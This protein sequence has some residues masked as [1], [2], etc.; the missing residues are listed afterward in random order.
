M[1]TIVNSH[2]KQWCNFVCCEKSSSPFC[3]ALQGGS[4]SHQSSS[5]KGFML[6]LNPDTHWSNA[7]YRSLNVL[8]LTDRSN[9]LFVNRDVP[10]GFVL[11]C[12]QHTISFQIQLSREKKY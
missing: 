8:L 11:I 4:A 5:K 9:I 6:K 10:P 3:K 12:S 1:S 7:L 2:M